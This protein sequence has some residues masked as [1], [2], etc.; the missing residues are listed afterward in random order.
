MIPAAESVTSKKSSAWA[1][2]CASIYG[3][4]VRGCPFTTKNYLILNRAWIAAF[5]RALWAC[6]G[7]STHGV[8]F[9]SLKVERLQMRLFLKVIQINK[10]NTVSTL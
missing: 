2:A 4:G 9:H 10:K 3:R 5:R 6:P 1:T 8:I 7:T